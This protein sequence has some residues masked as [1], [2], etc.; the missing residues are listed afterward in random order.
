MS[1]F[2]RTIVISLL[3][4]AVCGGGFL[5]VHAAT[6][7]QQDVNVTL[8]VPSSGG[9]GG[10]VG[11]GGPGDNPPPN[12]PP[13]ISNV[14][15]STTFTTAT[16]TW[17]ATDD[18]QITASSFVY[19]L[20]QNYGNSGSIT[21]SYQVALSGLATGTVYYFK[22]TVTDNGNKSTSYTG[23]FKTKVYTPPPDNTPPVISNIQTIP[24]VTTSSINWQ[25]NEPADSQVQYG[26][27]NAYGVSSFD[28]SKI[29]A[30]SVLLFNLLPNTI[31]HYQILSADSAGNTANTTD[32]AFQTAKDATPPPDVSGVE[33][34]TTSNTIK[35]SW[36]NP[37]LNAVPDFS[38]VKVVR[39][40]N[41]RSLNIND[42]TLVY[43]GSGQSFT[44]GNVLVNVTYFYTIFS[45][46]TSNNV[47]AGTF[48][49]GKITPP[50]G[51]S[52]VCNNGI[53]D[54]SNGA[55]DCADVACKDD[56]N[57]LAPPKKEI[58]NNGVDDDGDAKVDCADSDCNGNVN[59]KA[60]VFEICNNGIDDDA[61]GAIDCADSACGGSIFCQGQK[62][63][64]QEICMNGSDD[65]GNGKIDC[66]D[67]AC[68]GFSGCVNSV[69]PGTGGTSGLESGS[70]TVP[71]SAKLLV[72]DL[73][74]LA[75]NRT[76]TLEPK[77]NRVTS[78]AGTPLTIFL[79]LKKFFRTPRSVI[80]HIDN[81]DEH[82]FIFEIGSA[83]Y[84]TDITAPPIG[85]HPVQVVIDYGGEQVDT[86]SLVLESLALGEIHTGDVAPTGVTVL[87]LTPEGK[88]VDTAPSGFANPVITNANGTYGWIV[89]NGRYVIQATKLGF[90]KRTTPGLTIDNNV[91]NVSI[92]LIAEPPSLSDS[93]NPDASLA[94]NI[95]NVA[96]N[97]AA[98]TK[99]ATQ[100]TAEKV[101]DT[102]K[103]VN[104]AAD[105]PEVEK[106]ASHVVAPA[107]VSV[108]AVSTVPFLTFAD[109]FPFLRFLFLQPL[110]LLGL[111]RR[112]G[113]G[114]VYNALNKLPVDLATVRLINATTGKIVQSKVTDKKGRYAF[115]VEPG[116]YRLEIS[117]GAMTFPST[118]LAAYKND[119]QKTDIYHGEPIKV[120]EE[121]AVITANIPLDPLGEHKKPL[122][123]IWERFA[124][125]LQW[126]LSW[127][128]FGVTIVSLYI[129]PRWYV[130][131][132]L[133]VHLVFTALFWRL[134]KPPKVK[135]W[136]IVYDAGTKE[137]LSNAVARLFS[138][139]FNKLVATQ[140][141]D[142]KG[143]Y[144]F[145]AGDNRYYVTYD[146]KAYEQQRSDQ[147]DLSGKDAETI[148]LNVGLQPGEQGSPDQP[149]KKD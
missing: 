40:V 27:T 116:E 133:G 106:A 111:R 79:P 101:V 77:G 59:C 143:R 52:E 141:T 114:Q 42:G 110:M 55:I 76:I 130:W 122:R 25:T 137:P 14:A 41:S 4:L 135:S 95:T 103:I 64:V 6:T 125:K 33:L 35:V 54:D 46:D 145:L 120:S 10:G 108:I 75:G 30:H 84:S 37:S 121:G 13:T 43:T 85:Q 70:S 124:R 5:L 138:S 19:G 73:T 91:V 123:L 18:G 11:G 68:F 105:N 53:D 149:M 9:G 47:S 45:F 140:I 102:A 21:G 23:L 31:Y 87:L 90:Y 58:C 66:Y 139:Q 36:V 132:L 99:A 142:R 88:P 94:E 60:P 112:S 32:A 74:F 48:I 7:T 67:P 104:E 113:W 51:S 81:H 62:G 86:I 107:T 38:G 39:K 15:S 22:I 134:A 144:Y 16:I 72:S 61:N 83:R 49:S 98:K 96:K 34:S 92:S 117:K 50:V 119:G 3:S 146:H 97:L 109:V 131:V 57:C 1:R 2:V 89:P 128:G 65:D 148:A 118:L 126:I 28:V 100:R 44:D 17:N 136:G 129:A 82:Q 69:L 71:E 63:I 127:V 26:F 78:L 8:T 12:N 56:P 20:T 147:I 115:V 29:L 93:I 24:G 80:L